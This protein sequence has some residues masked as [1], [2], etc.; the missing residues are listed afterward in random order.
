MATTQFNA[1]NG[2]S[3]GTTP[4][5][6]LD[7]SGN[8]SFTSASVAA[9]GGIT[10]ASGAPG[11]TTNALYQVGSTLY[12]N[13]STL[14]GTTLPSQSGNNGK[15]LTTDGSNLSWATVVGGGGNISYSATFGDGTN[16]S[17]TFSHNLNTTDIDVDV[18]E[19]TGLLREAICEKRIIDANTVSVHLTSAPATNS[20]RITIRGGGFYSSP[21]NLSL[22]DTSASTSTTSGALV[23]A[24]GAGFGGT[25]STTS[26]D[27]NASGT[28]AIGSTNAS[29]INIGTGSGTT[30]I[31]IGS[32]GDTI[33]ISGTKT[34]WNSDNDGASST[35]DADLLDGQHGSYYAA[36]DLSGFY[37]GIPT[38]SAIILYIPIAR[39]STFKSSLSDSKGV[40]KTAATASTTFTVKRNGTSIGTMV[41]AASAT[42]ATFT[43]TGSATNAI[44]DIISVE[45]P[46]TA[47]A[48]L[49]DIGFT[50]YNSLT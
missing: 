19:T 3:V 32:S 10:I 5:S 21:A 14:G 35:L 39:A 24:G 42:T 1:R 46:S 37:G 2:L 49:A 47:D 28:L 43:L 38:A 4:V 12:W 45:A 34:Y 31:N 17:Y 33:T 9:N 40:A 50:L 41:F 36:Y 16:T 6:I 30:T 11:V 29:T 48:T 23:V 8:A 26:V 15:F 7:A 18:W 20:L 22:S 25:V 44:G 13:G 27:T